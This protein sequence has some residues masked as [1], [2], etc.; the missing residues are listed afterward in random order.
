MA[1]KPRMPTGLSVR[2]RAFWRSSLADFELSGAELE[3][4][5]EAVVTMT[6]LDGLREAMLRTG[7]RWSAR[8]ARTGCVRR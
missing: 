1:A 7:W 4:L 2:A 6:E 8:G 3:L 5:A